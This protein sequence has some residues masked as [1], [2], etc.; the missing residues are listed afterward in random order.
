[1]PDYVILPLVAAV[2]FLISFFLSS[3]GWG[4]C[5]I[6]GWSLL[7]KGFI[8]LRKEKK[9]AEINNGNEKGANT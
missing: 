3:I 9:C 2:V 8:S 4:I 5:M 7:I 1:M 6:V